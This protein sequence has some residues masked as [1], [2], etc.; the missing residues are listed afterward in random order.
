MGQP[1]ARIVKINQV[2][3]GSVSP[4]GSGWVRALLKCLMVNRPTRYRV[5]V[6][7]RSKIE[8]I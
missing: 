7:T 4:R 8:E 1:A 3:Y 2:G 5:M 6:L